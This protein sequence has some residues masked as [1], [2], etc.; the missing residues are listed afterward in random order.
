MNVIGLFLVFILSSAPLFAQPRDVTLFPFLALGVHYK[1][2]GIQ[3]PNFGPF[4]NGT[5]SPSLALG[6]RSESIT[7]EFGG[8]I[9]QSKI[10]Y[11]S[12][13]FHARHLRFDVLKHVE[14]QNHKNLE[15]LFGTGIS[16]F[17]W[18]LKHVAISKKESEKYHKVKKITP[19]VLSGFSY[20]LTENVFFR[21]VAVWEPTKKKTPLGT[22]KNTVSGNI[23][24]LVYI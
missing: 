8:D 4:P 1:V 2:S 24:L 16:R 20:Q 18:Q 7:F 23:G 19:K 13:K 17:N 10:S 15:L 9:A 3:N 6:F 21:A 5:I 11:A 14:V 22:I 12:N